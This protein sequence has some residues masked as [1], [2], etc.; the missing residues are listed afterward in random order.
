MNQRVLR[1]AR[2]GPKLGVPLAVELSSLDR[3]LTVDP[4]VFPCQSTWE[5]LPALPHVE[6]RAAR[7]AHEEDGETLSVSRP[8]ILPDGLLSSKTNES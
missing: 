5:P 4:L 3:V 1:N 7:Y 6:S 8:E 2:E